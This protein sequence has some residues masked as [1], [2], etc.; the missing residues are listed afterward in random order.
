MTEESTL[1]ILSWHCGKTFRIIKIS[2]KWITLLS[3]A[4]I[5]KI[6]IDYNLLPVILAITVSDLQT[7]QRSRNLD[8]NETV[9]P[10]FICGS[11]VSFYFNVS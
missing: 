2:S 10:F 7:I 3:P 11:A 6:K 8:S 1:G 9:V 5:I 4:R